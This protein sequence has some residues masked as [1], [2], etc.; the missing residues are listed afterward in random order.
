M[1]TTAHST[2]LPLWPDV[3]PGSEDWFQQEQESYLPLPS[4]VPQSFLPLPF[5]IKIARNIARPQLMAYLPAPALATGTA[6]IVCPGGAFNFLSIE[7]EGAEIARW[8]CARGITAFVLKYRVAPTAERD[9]E[10]VEQLRERFNDFRILLELMQQTEPLAQADGLQAIKLVRQR[11]AEWGI[12]PGRIGILGFS[13]GGVVASGAAMCYT[14]ESRPDF[15]AAIYHA[16]ST[17]DI[18]VPTDA[19]ALFLLAASDD[20]MAVGASLPLYSAWK[21]ADHPVEL[22]LYA[23]GGHAFALKKRGLPVD[24]WPERFSEWLQGLAQ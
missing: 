2:A 13:S 14:A 1:Y 8:L 5:E 10:F 7:L 3:V 6:V 19:P 24:D 16:P 15:A 4:E 18:T 9:E 11:S 23:Q 20:A 21:D 17:R 12:E 22:H